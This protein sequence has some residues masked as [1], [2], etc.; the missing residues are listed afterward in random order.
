[1]HPHPRCLL[2]AFALVGL[3]FAGAADNPVDEAAHAALRNIRATYE[4]AASTGDLAPLKA[5]FAPETSAV[6]TLGTEIKSF[7]ELEAHWSYVRGL[8]G[9]GG[10]YQTT[11]KPETSLIFGDL[12]LARGLSDEV[13]R[14]GNGREFRFE[15]KWTAV[16]RQIDGQWKVLRLHASMDPVNNVFTAAFQKQT[17]LTYGVGGIGLGLVVGLILGRLFKRKPASA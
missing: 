3:S 17:R 9:E 2:A 11:L 1:M 7:A 12:A 5:L 14:T 8:L 15:S 6:M 13:A 4:K 10:T 16:C